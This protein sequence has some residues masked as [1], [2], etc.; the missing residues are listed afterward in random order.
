MRNGFGAATRPSSAAAASSSRAPA[1][2]HDARPRATEAP[3]STT[4]RAPAAA[5]TTGC[6]TPAGAAAPASAASRRGGAR[7]REVAREEMG[8]GARV[9]GRVRRRLLREVGREALVEEDDGDVDDAR[10]A[11]STNCSVSR[12]CSPRSPRS[13]SGRPT[14]TCSASSSLDEPRELGEPVLGRGPLDD[15]E[16][17]RDRSRSGRRRRRRCAPSRS[18]APSPSCERLGDRLLAGLERVAH[19]VGVLAARL[20]ERRLAAAAAADVLAELAHELRRVEAA[21]R[22]ATRRS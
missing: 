12:A 5:P 18:R 10:A 11:L 1:D 3:T 8:G 16:R 14:T 19:A 4:R 22:R 6:A 7:P 2:L 20:G 17:P 13:V 15:A 9:L 21:L